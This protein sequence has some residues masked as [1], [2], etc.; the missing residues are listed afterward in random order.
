MLGVSLFP[1]STCGGPGG[2]SPL[3]EGCGT[4]RSRHLV[5]LDA[6]LG[7]NLWIHVFEGSTP[8]VIVALNRLKRQSPGSLDRLFRVGAALQLIERMECSRLMVWLD[9]RGPTAAFPLRKRRRKTGIETYGVLPWLLLRGEGV[10]FCLLRYWH[11]VTSPG[12]AGS[13]TAVSSYSLDEVRWVT[14]QGGL[15]QP[16]K[17]LASLRNLDANALAPEVPGLRKALPATAPSPA[18]AHGSAL[19]AGLVSAL[20]LL[21]VCPWILKQVPAGRPLPHDYEALKESL[22]IENNPTPAHIRLGLARP[23]LRREALAASEVL[24][25]PERWRAL[26]AAAQSGDASLESTAIVLLGRLGTRGAASLSLVYHT[27]SDETVRQSALLELEALDVHKAL[28]AVLGD[29]DPQSWVQRLGSR[30][31]LEYNRSAWST[32]EAAARAGDVDQ[33]VQAIWALC[34]ADAHRATPV[35]ERAFQQTVQELDQEPDPARTRALVGWGR[36]LVRAGRD[37]SVHIALN[38]NRLPPRVRWVLE[39]LLHAP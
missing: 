8:D 25:R 26:R 10:E 23:E 12:F 21:L 15:R 1:C 24:P 38:H 3:C 14:P 27:A 33:R 20:G 22:R 36:W 17:Q 2:R 39:G 37:R 30:A 32:L 9:L 19:R 28:K 35:V 11:R 7:D 34:R 5:P 16:V 4:P 31:P 13:E 29:R 6:C 18:P